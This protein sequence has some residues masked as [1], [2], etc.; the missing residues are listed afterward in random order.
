MYWD[1][2]GDELGSTW[3]RVR[4]MSSALNDGR[5]SVSLLPLLEGGLCT[6]SDT[7]VDDIVDEVCAGGARSGVHWR[8]VLYVA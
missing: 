1:G 7:E 6:A 2:S 8:E 4:C 3:G 5:D